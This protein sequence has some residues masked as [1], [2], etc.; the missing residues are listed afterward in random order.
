MPE[1][2]LA[3]DDAVFKNPI[4]NILQRILGAHLQIF[5][6]NATISHEK[7]LAFSGT[8]FERNIIAEPPKFVGDDVA[9][10]E[11]DV[12]AFTKSLDA[13]KLAVCH[14]DVLVIP[15]RSAAVFCEFAARELQ[16]A[17]M[18]KAV[19]KIKKRLLHTHVLTFLEGAFT[20]SRAVEN[21][22]LHAYILQ[23]IQRAFFIKLLILNHHHYKNS[24][25]K[26]MD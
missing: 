20:V 14:G 13:M 6:L 17:I 15:E 10:F 4:L 9:V 16:T 8:V 24:S 21:A 19:A 25:L 11:A 5:C 23:T 1:S 22:V 3:V 12:L 7:I 26:R 18:P 2:V